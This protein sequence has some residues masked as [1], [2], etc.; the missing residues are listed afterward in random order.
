[1]AV[2]FAT[3]FCTG[4]D[5]MIGDRLDGDRRPAMRGSTGTVEAAA[6]NSPAEE[7]FLGKTMPRSENRCQPAREGNRNAERGKWSE[8][9]TGG[10]ARDGDAHCRHH[11]AMPQMIQLSQAAETIM[12]SIV[13]RPGISVLRE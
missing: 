6:R 3:A 8:R 7:Q 13:R 12:G 10:R 1:M 9:S 11:P 5:V 2:R 4:V